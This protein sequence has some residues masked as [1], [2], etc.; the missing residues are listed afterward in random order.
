DR[1]LLQLAEPSRTSLVMPQQTIPHLPL[2]QPLAARPVPGFT[3]S[4]WWVFIFSILCLGILLG[5]AISIF[6]PRFDTAP[7]GSVPPPSL[8]PDPELQPRAPYPGFKSLLKELNLAGWKSNNQAPISRFAM[9]DFLLTLETEPL[10]D[11]LLFTEEEYLDYSLHI[12]YRWLTD[13]GHTWIYLRKQNVDLVDP[14]GLPLSID[15]TRGFP[16]GRKLVEAGPYRTGSITHFIHVKDPPEQPTGKWNRLWV[17][18]KDGQLRIELNSSE[19]LFVNLHDHRGKNP[20]IPDA[21]FEPGSIGIL[22]HHGSLQFRRFE[23]RPNP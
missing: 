17:L 4:N 20:M 11:Q 10:D 3:R 22:A 19:L 2:P 23:I 1:L 7:A 12:E 6:G 21:I 8:S 9:K 18:L 5:L 13:W 16:P 14:V 15:S